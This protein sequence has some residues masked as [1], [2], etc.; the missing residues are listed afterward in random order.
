[1]SVQ[2]VGKKAETNSIGQF[3]NRVKTQL[4]D[5]LDDEPIQSTKEAF[6]KWRELGPLSIDLVKKMAVEEVRYDRLV[7]QSEEDPGIFGQMIDGVCTGVGKET[8]QGIYE[9]Q[10]LDN[11]W[12]GFGRRIISNGDYYLGFWKDGM[13]NGW[14]YYV[15]NT[16]VGKQRPGLNRAVAETD[17]VVEEGEW[18]DDEFKGKQRRVTLSDFLQ[19][20]AT[21]KNAKIN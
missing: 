8:E 12:N 5:L 7:Q 11:E 15:Y 3:E 18:V 4:Q 16:Q 1:M 9:G 13:R 10:Y 6:A 21:F 14:G 17:L 2:K 20:I 19:N